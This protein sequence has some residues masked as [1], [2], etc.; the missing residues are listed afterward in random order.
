MKNLH[1]STETKMVFSEGRKDK[2]AGENKIV[3]PLL[4]QW[5]CEGQLVWCGAQFTCSCVILMMNI[6][7]PEV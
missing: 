7:N 6:S 3:P 4:K 2:H 1:V 5:P